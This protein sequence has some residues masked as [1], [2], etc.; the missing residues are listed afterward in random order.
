MRRWRRGGDGLWIDT[1]DF[2]FGSIHPTAC[3]R[4]VQLRR[5]DRAEGEIHHEPPYPFGRPPSNAARF[6]AGLPLR[7]S[8]SGVGSTGAAGS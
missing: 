1:V 4:Y 6:G 3:C 2:A 7:A 8:G 5:V